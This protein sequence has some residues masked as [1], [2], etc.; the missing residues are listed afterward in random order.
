VNRS[1]VDRE[2]SQAELFSVRGT[3]AHSVAL[4]ALLDESNKNLTSRVEPNQDDFLLIVKPINQ[5]SGAASTDD[6]KRIS[7][8]LSLSLVEQ[9]ERSPGSLRWLHFSC[10]IIFQMTRWPSGE[11][12]SS[13]IWKLSLVTFRG[14]RQPSPRQRCNKNMDDRH[15]NRRPECAVIDCNPRGI[16]GGAER[17]ECPSTGFLV[18]YLSRSSFFWFVRT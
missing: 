4:S 11:F 1:L 16:K 18:C 9:P 17:F 15:R 13:R 10:R 3:K 8:S 7:P 12:L 6:D 2:E 5:C 14:F